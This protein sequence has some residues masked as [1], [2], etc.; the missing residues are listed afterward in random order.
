MRA[1]SWLTRLSPYK[2]YG[3]TLLGWLAPS[4]VAT[5]DTSIVGCSALFPIRS[6]N[7]LQTSDHQRPTVAWRVG[8]V[9][10]RGPWPWHPPCSGGSSSAPLATGTINAAGSFLSRAGARPW[11]SG[12]AA[13][14]CIAIGDQ[15]MLSD[16]YGPLFGAIRA[17]HFWRRFIISAIHLL[18]GA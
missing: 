13:I 11:P 5:P 18:G 9:M 16:E 8:T 10:A 14:S 6:A 2:E 1:G 17:G 7:V 12:A 3:T 4:V 15:A